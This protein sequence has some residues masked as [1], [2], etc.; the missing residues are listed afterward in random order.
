MVLSVL[1]LKT[2]I[3]SIGILSF[4]L[5]ISVGILIYFLII[6]IFNKHLN[7]N[8]WRLLSHGLVS[9]KRGL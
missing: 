5:F 7:Y 4:I 6:Y 9:L 3:N 2:H 1:I 8:I